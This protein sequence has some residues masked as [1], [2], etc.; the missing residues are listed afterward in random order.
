MKPP[1]QVTDKFYSVS[2]RLLDHYYNWAASPL[3]FLKLVLA[4]RFVVLLITVI[5]FGYIFYDQNT[6]FHK[7]LTSGLLWLYLFFILAMLLL[8]ILNPD[9]FES[10]TLQRLQIIIDGIVISLLYWISAHVTGRPDPYIFFLYFLPLLVTARFFRFR[11]VILLI[12]YIILASIVVGILEFQNSAT[13]PFQY[14][15]TNLLPQFSFLF[16]FTIVYFTYYGR[17]RMGERLQ[18]LAWN[19]EDQ[20]GQLWQGWFSVDSELRVTSVDLAMRERH[21]VEL[22]D[23]TCAQAF[24]SEELT[25]GKFCSNCPLQKALIDGETVSAANVKLIDK[26][27]TK[28]S[29]Q[30]TAQPVLNMSQEIIGVNAWVQDLDERKALLQRQH[31]LTEDLERVIDQNRRDDRAHVQRLAKRLEAVSRASQSAIS[32]DLYRG[33]D[34]IV[35]AIVLL[36]GCQL[37]T[38]RQYHHN[39][40]TGRDG[41]IL[42]NYYGIN[43]KDIERLSVVEL[44]SSS[45]EVKAFR[46]GED[47]YIE[48]LQFSLLIRHEG[49]LQN[50]DLHSMACFPLKMQGEVIATFTLFGNKPQ[51]FS[52]EDLVLGRAVANIMAS[53]VASQR[54]IEIDQLESRR[55]KREL[56]ILSSLS[57]RLVTIDDPNALAQ[58]IVDIV[59]LEL[60][61]ETA[62]VFVKKEDVLQRTAI[63][64][65]DADW[66]P[67]ERYQI[68]QGLTGRAALAA[69]GPDFSRRMLDNDVENSDI[70]LPENVIR[71]SQA[72]LSGSVSH[73]LAVPLDGFEGTFGV[74]RIVN[75]LD[76][77]GKLDKRGFSEHEAELLTTT[78]CIVAVAM[79]NAKL[80]EKKNK[81]HLLEQALRQSARNLN[82]TL[83]EGKILEIILEL[84]KKVVPYDTA[85]LFLSEPD[86]LKLK[87][88]AGFSHEEAENLQNVCLDPEINPPFKRMRENHQPILVNDLWE[89]PLLEPIVGTPRIRA[90][91]G[92]PLI[93]RDQIMG[94][95]SVDSWKPNKFS[96]D[97]V[98]VA[99]DFAQQAA[100]AID[101][102]RQFKL[103]KEQVAA[104]LKLD[105][106]LVDISSDTDKNVTLNKIAV[107]ASQLTNCEVAGVAL[108]N[109]EKKEIRAVP[110][111]GYIGVPEEYAR[112][113]YFSLDHPG[114]KVLQEKR[115]YYSN[116]ASADTNSIFGHRL[117]DPIGAKGVIAAPLIVGDYIVGVLYAA[118]YSPKTWTESQLA[119]F[120]I[121]SNHAAIAIGNSELFSARERRA[122]LLDL[123]HHLSIAGQLTSDPEVIYNILLTAVTAE[124]GLHFNRAL[125]LLYN[126]E[127]NVLRGFTGIGQLERSEAFHLWESLDEKSHS[128]ENYIKDILSNGNIYYTP[129]HY[130]AKNI[131]IPIRVDTNEVFSRVFLRKTWEVVNPS[132]EL[133][134]LNED[135]YRIFDTDP[136]VVVPLLVNNEVMGMLIVDNKMTSDPIRQMELDLLESCASQAAAAIYRS[137]L[138]Q[139]VEERVHVLE[140]LQELTRAFSELAES[141][142]VLR[143]IAQAT[144]DVL[145]AD[146]S[147]LAPYDQSTNALL[148]EES[149]TAGARTDF[150]HTGTVS[151]HGLTTMA[152]QEPSG[153]L[154]I[155]DLKS[156]KDLRSQFAEQEGIQSVAVARLELNKSVV[157]MVYVNYRRSHW[158]SEFELNTLRMLAGQA[159]VAINNAHLLKKNDN[160]ATQRE[161]NRLR[162]DLH[163]VLNTYAFK[164]M[165]PAESIFEKEKGKRRRDPV[166]VQEAE[167]LWRFTR[168]LYQQLER[169]LIDMRDPILVERGLPEAVKSLI[170][171]SG[172]RGVNL[173]IDGDCR[174]SADV[175][176]ILYRIC[177]EAISNI[178]KHAKL[179]PNVDGLV[180]I[181]LELEYSQSRLIVQDSGVGFSPE[182]GKDYKK[183]MGLQAM[184]NWARKVSAVIV[185][186]PIPGKGTYLEVICPMNGK[187]HVQ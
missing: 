42:C 28:Y 95:L 171:S 100:I 138:H 98:E 13:L 131:E 6:L 53:L 48:D 23:S 33:A 40:E 27:G 145:H 72:L 51:G 31:L 150:K 165:E 10:P 74:L 105:Q 167:E 173:A 55:R 96:P 99:Q 24:C 17:R 156:Q 80:L 62:A 19:V 163:D 186:D 161:R 128:F 88:M 130:K 35:H 29:A 46:T 178:R 127:L 86:G 69:P 187:E 71:Y 30:I 139:Q 93:I 63:S 135:F 5:N 141:R 125:L 153:L 169:I 110:D 136:F 45:L 81:Q 85:T 115:V 177:Q 59:R 180:K 12:L 90:W 103:Q 78:A 174:P 151:T 68:G 142:E 129:L 94:W 184:R 44:N 122:Q 123:L 1:T 49:P 106:H 15:F 126:K 70:A 92:A 137:N 20:I 157:G 9:L 41:L 43:P 158:F 162:E 38:V 73:L 75:K 147:Y 108:Y 39:D 22:G 164:V 60:H 107:A 87:S 18:T 159:A 61:A 119:L 132:Q 182:I 67:E 133:G 76:L 160:L 152:M 117:I 124:Y 32:S 146:I 4:F 114:G 140:R 58:M 83:E 104:L 89:E 176:L 3:E 179:P 56:D 7:A 116:D 65:L 82:S 36:L 52:E 109:K 57:Q 102:A 8:A 168:H 155:E 148:V 34:E 113:F 120:S 21:H 77:K 37:A 16:I 175:E 47:Q 66:F 181:V 25:R 11:V 14:W 149:V 144:N 112:N 111:V 26:S 118:S 97:D 64:G 50:Y 183:G 134:R 172:L 185:I 79:E 154:V 166:L 91:I 101:N 54:K 121:L 143:R 84:L 2:Q 170:S